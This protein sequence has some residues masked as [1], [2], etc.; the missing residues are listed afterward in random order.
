MKGNLL[1]PGA[2]G[3]GMGV[4]GSRAGR[5]GPEERT[6]PDMTQTHE[7]FKIRRP[8]RAAPDRPG[9]GP[10]ESFVLTGLLELAD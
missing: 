10:H 1:T 2:L 6:C 5:T 7:R 8:L 4:V 9:L 3:G